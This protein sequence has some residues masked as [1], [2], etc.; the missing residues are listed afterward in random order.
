MTTEDH[1][2][3]V[4]SVFCSNPRLKRYDFMQTQ[5]MVTAMTGRSGLANKT[6]KLK[7][8]KS[9][10]AILVLEYFWEAVNSQ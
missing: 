6:S 9:I 10:F 3:D 7:H 5:G 4:L 1:I 2:K 8:H